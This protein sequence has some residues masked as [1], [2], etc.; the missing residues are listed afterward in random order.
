MGA[1][2]TFDLRLESTAPHPLSLVVDC[3]PSCRAA[4]ALGDA[5]QPLA[6]GQ[7]HRLG[8]ELACFQA[9]GAD[10]TRIRRVFELSAGDRAEVSLADVRIEPPARPATDVE[11]PD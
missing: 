11:C 3:D 4:V 7:W 2:L 5:L 8:I 10:L 9:A 1:R 6:I